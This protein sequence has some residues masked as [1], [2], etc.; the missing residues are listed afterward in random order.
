[1]TFSISYKGHRFSPEVIAHAV[2]LDHRFP[3]SLRHVEEMLLA[4]GIQ[5][6]YE[7][8]RRWG[9]KFGPEVAAAVRRRAPK[10]GDVWHLDEMQVKI[11]GKPVLAVA[12]R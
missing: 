3:L 7:T 4:R 11:T 9:A 10:R 6:S 2:W 1:M 12:H 5:V 8:I